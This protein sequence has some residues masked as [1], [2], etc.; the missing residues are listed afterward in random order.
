MKPPKVETP[1]LKRNNPLSITPNQRGRPAMQG[2]QRN[3]P[4]TQVNTSAQRTPYQRRGSES[5]GS[6]QMVKPVLKTPAQKDAL[7]ETAKEVA[8]DSVPSESKHPVQGKIPGQGR[9]P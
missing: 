6:V 2:N 5:Q 3:L 7:Q 9:V 8:Q 4:S 1:P